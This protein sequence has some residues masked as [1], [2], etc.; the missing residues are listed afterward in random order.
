MLLN[1][2][3]LSSRHKFY[4]SKK[5]FSLYWIYEACWC[6]IVQI[7]NG[8]LN[9]VIIISLPEIIKGSLKGYLNVI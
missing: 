6:N 5:G 1:I 7:S 9:E 8:Y 3:I 4:S 2:H